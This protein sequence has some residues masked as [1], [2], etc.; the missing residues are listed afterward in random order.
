[1]RVP[2]LTR[3]T[4]NDAVKVGFLSLTMALVNQAVKH[5]RESTRYTG[6]KRFHHRRCQG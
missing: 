6:A 2:P 1:M 4:V 3:T 5:N